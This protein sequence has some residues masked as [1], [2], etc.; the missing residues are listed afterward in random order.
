MAN[1]ISNKIVGESPLGLAMWKLLI[2]LAKVVLV[3]RWEQKPEEIELKT[4]EILR[5]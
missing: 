2:T 1:N 4:E 5:K 3:E